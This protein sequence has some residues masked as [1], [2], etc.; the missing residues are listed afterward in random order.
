VLECV[1]V[2]MPD[3]GVMVTYR[4]VTDKMR[5]EIALREKADA[6]LEAE[7]LKTDF[8]ANVSYQLRTPLN[9]M[10]GFAE[11]LSNDYFGPLTDKQKEYTKGIID[12]GAQLTTLIDDILDLTQIEAGMM[13]LRL[14]SVDVHKLVQE[15][16]NLT[17]EW[18]GRET[19]QAVLDCPTDIGM[20]RADARRLKQVLVNLIRNAISFTPGGGTISLSASGTGSEVKITVKDSG[21]GISS[22]DQEQVFAPFQRS[23]TS[24]AKGGAAGPGLGLPLVRDITRMHGGDV[25]MLSRLGEGTSVTIVLPRSGPSD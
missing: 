13:S 16:F 19:L 23:A 9:A 11:I 25:K 5:V 20:I 10:T 18:A 7:K 22:D 12:A 17:R 2:P 6:L 24:N 21:I 3:G 14:Q 1:S 8:L 15:V 4:D